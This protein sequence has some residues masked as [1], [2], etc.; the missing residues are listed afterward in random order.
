[1]R[2]RTLHLHMQAGKQLYRKFK[3]AV[4]AFAFLCAGQNAFSQNV[5][6]NTN[7]PHPSASLEV[8]GT[9]KGL[10]IPRISLQSLTDNATIPNP[11]TALLIY[12]TNA[13]IGK[14]GF[15]YNSG[16]SGNPIWSSVGGLEFPSYNSPNVNAAAFYLENQSQSANAIGIQATTNYGVGL[17]GSTVF[18]QG[19]VGYA[20][21]NGTGVLAEAQNTL[22]TALKVKGK[23][24]IAGPGQSPGAGKVLTSDANGYATWENMGGSVAFSAS[25]IK[26]GGSEKLPPGISK[27]P[28]AVEEYDLGNNYNDV[29]AANHSTFTAPLNGIYRFEMALNFNGQIQDPGFKAG[30][31]LIRTRNGASTQISE[32]NVEFEANGIIAYS[33]TC[34]AL[35]GDQF[36]IDV[37]ISKAGVELFVQPDANYFSGHLVARK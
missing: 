2:N 4:V 11:A 30:L 13:G 14:K 27:V 16:T 8:A 22:G 37:Y 35:I 23:I 33:R 29:N 7:N 9:D 28:F 5:G 34:E 10:L 19:V 12:N 36:H 31:A 25:G 6:V 3:T 20:F 18:G 21:Q 17:H 24:N 32:L 1:M 15:F 26:G